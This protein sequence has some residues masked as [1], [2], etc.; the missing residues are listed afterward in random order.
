MVKAGAADQEEDEAVAKE[1]EVAQEEAAAGLVVTVMKVASVMSEKS[2]L[3]ELT[4]FRLY[5]VLVGVDNI[6]RV[7]YMKLLVMFFTDVSFLLVLVI[8]LCTVSGHINL[9]L[10]TFVLS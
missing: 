4:R 9:R 3:P 10:D 6:V 2:L 7:H 8:F 1:V 5:S